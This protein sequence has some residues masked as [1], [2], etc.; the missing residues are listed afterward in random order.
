M[1]QFLLKMIFQLRVGLSPIKSHKR[2]QNFQDTPVDTCNCKRSAETNEHLLFHWPLYTEQRRV[3]LQ[4]LNPILL[5]NDLRFLDDQS[6]LHLL[7]YGHEKF[8]YQ[9]N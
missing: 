1:I 5:A 6:L 3:L 4:T 2:S 8:H 9:T 7:L